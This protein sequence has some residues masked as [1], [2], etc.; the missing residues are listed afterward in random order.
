MYN[1]LAS[2]CFSLISKIRSRLSRRRNHRLRKPTAS[3]FAPEF[4]ALDRIELLSTVALPITPSI[5][6]VAGRSSA[7][8]SDLVR[9]EAIMTELARGLSSRPLANASNVKSSNMERI[10]AI[11]THA[12]TPFAK[13]T[14][15]DRIAAIAAAPFGGFT[16]QVIL[17][18]YG[19][20]QIAL[21]TSD[22]GSVAGT[23]AGETIAIVDG[24]ADPNIGLEL[25]IYDQAFGLPAPPSLT[26]LNQNGG[27]TPPRTG[28]STARLEIAV[29]VETAHA[30][31][32]GANIVLVETNSL[33]TSSLLA[34]V[35]VARAVPG[36]VAVSMS[37]GGGE[38]AGQTAYDG[39]FHTPAGHTGITF[40]ASSGDGGGRGGASWPASSPN[41]VGVG[42]TSIVGTPSGVYESAWSGSGGGVSRF[43][44]R[45]SFQQNFVTPSDFYQFKR[46]A[47]SNQLLLNSLIRY[48]Q[49]IGRRATPDVSIY[50]DPSPGIDVFSIADGGWT[51]AGGT[52]LGPPQWSGLIAIADQGRA[53]LGKGSLDGATQTLP[54]LYAFSGDFS[55]V[56]YGSNGTYSAGSGYNL[57]TGLG[58]PI[59]PKL[60][61]DLVAAK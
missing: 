19:F 57:V 6:P 56:L 33:Q 15:A 47:S 31:A 53:L 46:G 3:R 37:W 24:G 16:P 54:D 11:S 48:D 59:A 10:A 49:A 43:E 5:A 29:D 17:D 41:V 28:S 23:G 51:R 32:P 45:P 55:P 12:N 42:G 50:G 40:L 58:T 25:Q 30:A 44:P 13:S 8:R 14:R 26:I 1:H 22:G 21:R 27:S 2:T 38:F 60:V 52:S 61:A 4:D 7:I 9:R 35:N 39:E 18:R 36:V 34:G 20:N